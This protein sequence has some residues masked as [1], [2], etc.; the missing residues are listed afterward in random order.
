MHYGVWVDRGRGVREREGE[1][2][3]TAQAFQ[4][5]GRIHPNAIDVT[6][7]VMGGLRVC[8]TPTSFGVR[9]V[10]GRWGGSNV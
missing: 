4:P 7:K 8:K 6:K 1:V 10:W 9:W 5:N 2:G 3:E